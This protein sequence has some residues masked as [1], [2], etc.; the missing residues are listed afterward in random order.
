LDELNK[1]EHE[2]VASEEEVQEDP[3]EALNGFDGGP[4]AQ[5]KKEQE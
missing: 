1:V 5:A 3:A 2:E 4:A